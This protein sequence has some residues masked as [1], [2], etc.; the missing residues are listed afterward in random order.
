MQILESKSK[1]ARFKT[2]EVEA[3][4]LTDSSP[5]PKGKATM[6]LARPPYFF[7][8]EQQKAYDETSA[9]LAEQMLKE[10]N[11]SMTVATSAQQPFLSQQRR[12]QDFYG[13]L[14]KIERTSFVGA[15][16]LEAYAERLRD[17][18]CKAYWLKRNA[19]LNF[20]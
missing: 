17:D 5:P 6:D 4:D 20:Y 9:F 10:R 19:N 3:V 1:P 16:F 8:L 12:M 11:D 2:P 18:L 13:L 14:D 7:T 15:I